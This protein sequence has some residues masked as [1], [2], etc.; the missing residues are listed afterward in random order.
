MRS[1]KYLMMLTDEA[2]V[3]DPIAT[4][5]FAE[6]AARGALVA[7]LQAGKTENCHVVPYLHARVA[8]Y[9][10]APAGEASASPNARLSS[11]VEEPAAGRTSALRSTTALSSSPFPQY[12][13]KLSSLRSTLMALP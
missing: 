10:A 7:S 1:L 11:R 6:M 4:D 13:L 9:A 12:F 2:F 3:I 5:L 8:A